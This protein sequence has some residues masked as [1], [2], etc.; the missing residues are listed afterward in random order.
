MT[1]TRDE[2]RAHR[3][4]RPVRFLKLSAIFV[5][6]MLLSACASYTDKTQEMRDAYTR[7]QWDEALAALKGFAAQATDRAGDPN[8]WEALLLTARAG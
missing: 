1:F 2:S 6:S 5:S 4:G 7:G 3:T 8:T